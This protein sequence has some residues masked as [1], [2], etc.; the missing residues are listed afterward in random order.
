MKWWIVALINLGL[1]LLGWMLLS[2]TLAMM[3]GH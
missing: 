3:G 2:S 1:L